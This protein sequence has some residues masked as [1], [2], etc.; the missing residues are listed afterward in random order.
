MLSTLRA[1]EDGVGGRREAGGPWPPPAP[2]GV[3]PRQPLRGVAGAALG[4]PSPG[5]VAVAGRVTV[6]SL[7]CDALEEAGCLD[8][9]VLVACHTPSHVMGFWVVDL[10]RGLPHLL[11]SPGSVAGVVGSPSVPEL[12]PPLQRP[13]FSSLLKNRG[14]GSKSL[15]FSAPRGLFQQAVRDVS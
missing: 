12:C 7:G 11:Y 13:P 9:D 6:N 15:K 8:P 10:L 3:V 4:G 1:S 5:R 14:N 2:P